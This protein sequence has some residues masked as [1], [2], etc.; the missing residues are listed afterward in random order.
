LTFRQPGG[1]DQTETSGGTWTLD[2]DKLE[3]EVPNDTQTLYIEALEPDRL[4]V[5]K[6]TCDSEPGEASKRS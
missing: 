2:R 5:R 4:V 1:A 6:G 3:L